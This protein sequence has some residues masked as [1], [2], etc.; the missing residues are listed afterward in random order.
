M[1]DHLESFA[2]NYGISTEFIL[3]AGVACGSLFLFVGLATLVTQRD[4]ATV[5]L[6]H[7]ANSRRKHR[8][9]QG[10]LKSPVE[11]ATGLM[12]SFLPSDL[13]KRTKLHRELAQA[14][15]TGPHALRNFTF[16]RIL[17]GLVLPGWLL[18]LLFAGREFGSLFPEPFVA[19]VSGYSSMSIFRTIGVLVAVGY[20]L[21]VM[22]LRSRIAE[23]KQRITESFPNA[24]DLMQI[25]LEAGMGFD[26]AMTRVGNELSEIAPDIAYEFLTVQHQV[27]AG[28]P[29]QAAMRDM[30]ERT[31]VEVVASFANVVH[32]AMH[33]GTSMSE[34]LTTYANE[35]RQYREMKAQELA[36]KLPVKLSGVMASLMLPALV[37][38]VLGPLVIRWGNM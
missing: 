4:A 26:I 9:D 19:W 2:A 22:W 34:A 18:L 38:L 27:Q 25:S 16:V 37:I 32:Q 35:M 15:I 17:L 20:F 8:Q 33:F 24:L 28:R 5:R 12:R 23:R 14:G 21:P 7:A 3:L 30:A 11:E 6:A 10:I 31:G 1:L 13:A 29:R 36:N